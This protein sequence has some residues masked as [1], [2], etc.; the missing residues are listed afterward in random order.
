MGANAMCIDSW[1]D[2]SKTDDGDDYDKKAKHAVRGV[3]GQTFP[4]QGKWLSSTT[5]MTMAYPAR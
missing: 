1:V 5:I 2:H 3:V 4:F